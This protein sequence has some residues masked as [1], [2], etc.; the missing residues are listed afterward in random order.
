MNGRRAHILRTIKQRES[1]L[2]LSA[3]GVYNDFSAMVSNLCIFT[4]EYENSLLY[5][6]IEHNFFKLNQVLK[7]NKETFS[8]HL[9]I[10]LLIELI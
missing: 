4:A 9:C 10:I 7:Q 2:V 1:R 6:S 5:F 8:D 3:K